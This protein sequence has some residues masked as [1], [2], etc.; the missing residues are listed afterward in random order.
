[1]LSVSMADIVLNKWYKMFSILWICDSN[2]YCQILFYIS[3]IPIYLTDHMVE[4]YIMDWKIINSEHGMS[5]KIPE[6]YVCRIG[7][8]GFWVLKLYLKCS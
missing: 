6:L 7:L 4:I 2:P 5:M 8:W 1:M 3:A